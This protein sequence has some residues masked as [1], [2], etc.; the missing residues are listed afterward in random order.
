LLGA[1]VGIAVNA[2]F[3]WVKSWLGDENLGTATIQ[4]TINGYGN[5]SSTRTAFT[6][7]RTCDY[8]G[9]GSFYRVSFQ[10]QLT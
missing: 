1:V 4:A 8:R 7:I 9:H 10:W 6:P 5:W 2:V 3:G